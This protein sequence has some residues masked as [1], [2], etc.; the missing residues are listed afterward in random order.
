MTNDK[1][2]REKDYTK[3][4]SQANRSANFP[5]DL[6]E[7]EV[8]L[9]SFLI[10]IGL[11]LNNFTTNFDGHRFFLS[12]PDNGSYYLLKMKRSDFISIF[13]KSWLSLILD[14]KLQIF[15]NLV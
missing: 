1:I 13:L 4:M 5:N 14:S 12:K 3:V 7:G 9:G 6:R 2:D 11:Y 8:V 15:E 10:L